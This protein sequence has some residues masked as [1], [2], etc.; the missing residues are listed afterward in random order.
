[1]GWQDCLVDDPSGRAVG[2]EAVT[3]A[4]FGLVGVLVGALLTAARE[5]LMARRQERASARANA[6]LLSVDLQRA[7]DAVE[8]CLLPGRA[9]R[10]GPWADELTADAWTE[11]L[12]LLARTTR[13]DDWEPV[14]RAF[15]EVDK[16]RRG[17][18]SSW[19]PDMKRSRA[20]REDLANASHHIEAA[21]G[22]LSR[23]ARSTGAW[24]HTPASA[25][26][27]R[28]GPGRAPVDPEVVATQD[29]P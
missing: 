5:Y 20:V 25:S 27:H 23:Q 17:I 8:Y 6:R 24:R 16:I 19:V 29:A 9:P 14:A 21:L 26:A 12:T 1:M 28:T 13:D 10:A 4:I 22:A 11:R 18:A 2:G 7:S 3:A 15:V